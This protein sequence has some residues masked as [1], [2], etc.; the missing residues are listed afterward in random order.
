MPTRLIHY[1]KNPLSRKGFSETSKEQ[2]HYV[3]VYTR[4]KQRE[5]LA[6]F[7]IHGRI[8][9]EIAVAGF[10]FA[11]RLNSSSAQDSADRWF[12]SEPGFV[13]EKDIDRLACFTDFSYPF[14]E[15][16]LKSS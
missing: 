3:R 14:G 16:F 2:V 10:D 15:F 1:K 5:I 4:K 6:V 11:N 9:V 8:S 12:Q 7:D 13:E